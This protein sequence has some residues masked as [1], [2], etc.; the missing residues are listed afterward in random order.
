MMMKEI[1]VLFEEENKSDLVFLVPKPQHNAQVFGR[2][3]IRF[4]KLFGWYWDVLCYIVFDILF[5]SISCEQFFMDYCSLCEKI[6]K[7]SIK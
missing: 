1:A 7:F 6:E 4:H 5:S 3:W 2:F